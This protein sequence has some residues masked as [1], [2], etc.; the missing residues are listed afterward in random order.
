[1]VVTRMTPNERTLVVLIL[2]RGAVAVEAM[3]LETVEELTRLPRSSLYAA[4]KALGLQTVKTRSHIAIPPSWKPP[5][6]K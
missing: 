1:M 5:K 3:S 4:V 6:V 2:E